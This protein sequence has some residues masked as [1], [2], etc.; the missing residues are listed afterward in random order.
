MNKSAQSV[1]IEYMRDNGFAMT[2]QRKVIVET[3]L[4]TE[5][6]FT[7]ESLCELVKNKVPDVGQ[8]TIYRT[9]K[10]LVESG[11]ADTIDG[12]DGTA[13]YEHDY[14]HSHHDHL[15]CVRCNKKIEVFDEAIEKRQEEV[16]EEY[17]FKLTRHRMYLYGVCSDCA[18]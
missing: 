3:F 18:E 16:A 5:G 15:I 13:L 10:L 11:L 1:F 17:D 9:L 6:H 12:L 4:E 7:A 8:A 14:G 2:P